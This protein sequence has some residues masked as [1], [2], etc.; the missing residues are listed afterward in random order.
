MTC[1]AIVLLLL[2]SCTIPALSQTIRGE[3]LDMEDKKPVTG[4]AIENI[5]TGLNITTGSDGSFLIAGAG[6]ELLEFR[7]PGYKTTH[8]RIPKGYIPPFF[9]IIITKGISPIKDAIA[10]KDGRYNYK[11]DSIKFHELYK[12]ELD[13]PKLNGLQAI[14]SPFSALSKK[15]RQIWQFQD[16]YAEF[17]KERYVDKTFSDE[18]VTRFTGLTGDSLMAYK[19]RYRPSYEQLRSMNDYTFYNFIKVT[20]QRFRR[21]DR[22]I[23]GQ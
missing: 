11:D 16:D 6:G 14:A 10:S 7:K 12:H 15:N 4:V 17:E 22:P 20:V 9:R 18:V 1:R 23:F 21:P 8:V 2:L 5:F 19:R 13:F 3:V